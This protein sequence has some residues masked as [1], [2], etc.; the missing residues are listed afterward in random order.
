[1][2]VLETRLEMGGSSKLP[3]DILSLYTRIGIAGELKIRCLMVRI[4]L[5]TYYLTWI[6]VRK[7]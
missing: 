7:L 6:Y 1:M 3:E 5:E 2:R 4:H